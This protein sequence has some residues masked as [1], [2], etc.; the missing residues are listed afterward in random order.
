VTYAADLPGVQAD[1]RE[2]TERG[3]YPAEFS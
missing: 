3:L 1:V 2:M